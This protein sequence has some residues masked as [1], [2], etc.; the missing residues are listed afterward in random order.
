MYCSSFSTWAGNTQT[1]KSRILISHYH[2]T[3]TL[4]LD[5]EFVANIDIFFKMLSFSCMYA[6]FLM[7]TFAYQGQICQLKPTNAPK[8]GVEWVTPGTT[9]LLLLMENLYYDSAPP[10]NTNTNTNTNA[11]SGNKLRCKQIDLK[12]KVEKLALLQSSRIIKRKNP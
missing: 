5:L 12:M 10:P 7:V 4:L 11:R 1:Q 2:Q 9:L 6:I 3:Q 8:R